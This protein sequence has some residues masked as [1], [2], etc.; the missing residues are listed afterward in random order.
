MSTFSTT[1]VDSAVAFT[2]PLEAI[3]LL[4]G[5]VVIVLGL[6]IS[7]VLLRFYY[8]RYKEH[9]ADEETLVIIQ[10]TSTFNAGV[11]LLRVVPNAILDTAKNFAQFF[12]QT[13][14][15]L[16]VLV[17]VAF[18]AYGWNLRHDDIAEVVVRTIQCDIRPVLD[19]TIMPLANLVRSLYNAIWPLVSL[20]F[21]YQVFITS[22]WYTILRGCAADSAIESF[23]AIFTQVGAAAAALARAIV[24]FFAGDISLDRFLLTDFLTEVGLIANSV[25]DTLD[26]FCDWLHPISVFYTSIP[27]MQALHTAIEAAVNL[28]I[29]LL[30]TVL[31][32]LVNQAPPFWDSP[33]EEAILLVISA[34][35]TFEQAARLVLD[36]LTDLINQIELS[37]A[38]DPETMRA[39][40]G[41]PLEY[42]EETGDVKPPSISELMHVAAGTYLSRSSFARTGGGVGATTRSSRPIWDIPAN[43]NLSDYLGFPVIAALLQ[44]PWSHI[45]SE[46]I[47]AALVLVNMTLNIVSNPVAI[48]QSPAAI[49]YFQVKPIYDHL[50][51]WVDAV[52]E[53]LVIIDPNFPDVFSLF[54]QAF[55]TG[56]EA[57]YELG[58]GTINAIIFPRWSFGEPPPI[59]CTPGTCSYG[60]LMGNWSVFEIFPD[61]YDWEG[62]ALRRTIGLL[63]EDA[64]AIAILLG[65]NESTLDDD[66]CTAMPFQ[67]FLRTTVLF[68]V[69]A[70]NQTLA[71]VLYLPD[72]VRFSSSLHTFQDLDLARLHDLLYLAVE[73]LTTWYDFFSLYKSHKTHTEE[74]GENKEGESDAFAR[75]IA[76]RAALG[77]LGVAGR[78]KG[79]TKAPDVFDR[80]TTHTRRV[81]HVHGAQDTATERFARDFVPVPDCD[82]ARFVVACRIHRCAKHEFVRSVVAKTVVG[83]VHQRSFQATVYGL[84]EKAARWEARIG[85]PDV[86]EKLGAVCAAHC[87]GKHEEEEGESK[88]RHCRLVKT[89]D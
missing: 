82:L 48:F 17:M 88:W 5:I 76:R 35:E 23:D 60:N 43:G 30:Q 47:A 83:R 63:Q 37:A 9:F 77:I 89:N 73:C 38:D 53:L 12:S 25:L 29:R 44:T 40:F 57:L 7:G 4:L 87:Q 86:S 49:A 71:L 50:R 46:P 80:R 28:G 75:G 79:L 45:A 66:N 33:F 78:V 8:G 81:D 6:S 36:L 39:L 58:I 56:V 20:G 26:C 21:N 42:D 1:L 55:F 62:N 11:S 10:A 2:V 68:S 85:R 16:I 31:N 41:L 84:T 34:G 24:T 32:A 72:L 13:L 65:C 64:D 61:Y 22:G 70:A 3:S 27:Q 67:C 18:L 19:D 14:L 51:T 59:D 69:E 15:P 54:G 52:C 74:E